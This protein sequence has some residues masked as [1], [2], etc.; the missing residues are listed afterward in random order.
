MTWWPKSTLSIFFLC[1][2][3]YDYY[4]IKSC[5]VGCLHLTNINICYVSFSSVTKLALTTNTVVV[6]SHFV[7]IIIDF[8]YKF[9]QK[10]GFKYIFSKKPLAVRLSGPYKKNGPATNQS[11]CR[12]H[13]KTGP[14]KN[15]IYSSF[16]LIRI[17][18]TSFK[19]HTKTYIVWFKRSLITVL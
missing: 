4:G 18:P 12:I 3:C 13:Y 9:L 15:K 1:A 5:R 14:L 2:K 10:V 17:G 6:L 7:I 8:L 19:V 11:D 16:Q